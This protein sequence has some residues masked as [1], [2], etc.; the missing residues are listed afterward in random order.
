MAGPIR[1][2]ILANG[3]QAKAEMRGVAT[4]A[5]VMGKAFR[6]TAGLV[7]GVFAVTE[8]KRAGEAVFK[9][10][11]EYVNSLNKIQALTGANNATMKRAARTLEAG[12]GAYAKMGQSTGDAAGGVVELTKAGLS[13]ADSLKAVRSTMV[14]AKAG[15]LDVADASTLV[16]NTLNTFSLK[17]KDAGKIANGL[18][19]AANISSADVSDLA[20]SFKYVSPIA[21]KAG[22]SL[23]QVDAILAEL[24]NSGVKASQAGTGLR[25]F[26][27]SL[28]APSGA[29]K[30]VIDDLGISIY[31]AQGKMLPFP[32]VVGN[33][34]NALKDLS[35]E[36]QN[37][38]LKTIFGLTG[39]TPAQIILKN[40]VK[41]LAAYTKGV[42]RA[43]AAQKLANAQSKG[44]AGTF[45]QI[46]AKAVSTAQSLYRQYSPVLNR[47][48]QD[49]IEW[50]KKNKEEFID[51]GNAVKDALVPPLKIL[52]GLAKTGAKFLGSL[53]GPVR[54]IGIEAGIAA[55]ILPRLT[56]GFTS[57]TGSLTLNIAKLQQWRAEMTYAE[58]RT[59]ALSG[60]MGK[61]GA[62]ARTT[63]G[64]GGMV[65]LTE[66]AKSSNKAINVLGETAGGA[67][68]GF[69]V[70]GPWGAAIGGGVGLLHS[71]YSA[72]HKSSDAMVDAKAKAAAYADA[73]DRIASASGKAARAEALRLIQKSGIIPEANAVGIQTPDL[74]SATLGN[75]KAIDRVTNAWKRQGS[76]VDA[77]TTDKL[78]KWITDQGF[79]IDQRRAAIKRDADAINGVRHNSD[80]AAR[81]TRRIN[82]ALENVG[83][84]RPGTDAFAR[85][86]SRGLAGV[87]NDAKK[88][89][90]KVNA[91]LKRAGNTKANTDPWLF[92]LNQAMTKGRQAA[93]SGG[94]RIG[95]ALGAGVQSGVHSWIGNV[96]ATAAELVNN[97]IAAAHQAADAHSPSRKMQR[98]G[99]D[100]G[101]GLALGMKEREARVKESQRRLATIATTGTTGRISATDVYRLRSADGGHGRLHTERIIER[102][103]SGPV[104]AHIDGF[105]DVAL[106][107][108]HGAIDQ[109]RRRESVVAGE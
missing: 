11:S 36:D 8:L 73:I 98:L 7:G 72:T 63:A 104:T 45:A 61:L 27:L 10:G 34:R 94:N 60:V 65:A 22:V 77:L 32:K 56:A 82:K 17:A 16:A 2:A 38:T 80:E 96:A 106:R 25:K 9:V 89:S 55:L 108:V 90:D 86:F 29:A 84:A 12:A 50:L 3:R 1:I 100:L 107:F 18:A 64:I 52:V 43:G 13:L 95:S 23:D 59:G 88:G 47:K 53:P 21:A 109:H 93:S 28:Q 48:I 76:V 97:A 6:R 51:A 68:T 81:A 49:L 35:Q 46:R 75:G 74:I 67:L 105:G 20:E 78:K 57:V 85:F 39:I 44:L 37:K 30:N 58:T 70:G 15:E 71:L 103:P 40:G 33:L 24:S 5:G 62:A 79:A 14:L 26:L 92:S 102:L 19:N 83:H 66:S 101:D 87:V 91:N 41:G 42:Q 54:N 69:A 31:D 99:H 4:Q